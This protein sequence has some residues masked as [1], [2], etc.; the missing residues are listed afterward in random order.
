[1]VR[2]TNVPGSD[3]IAT[4]HRPSRRGRRGRAAWLITAMLCMSS[5]AA[6]AGE[7][8]GTPGAGPGTSG[9]SRHLELEYGAGAP[10]SGPGTSGWGRHLELEYGTAPLPVPGGPAWTRH[11]ELEYGA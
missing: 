11:L 4:I 9:W 7:P 6:A 2:S 5:I 10:G 8:S 1:M 3:A